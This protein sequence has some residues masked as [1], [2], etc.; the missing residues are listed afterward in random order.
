[1]NRDLMLQVADFIDNLPPSKFSM[2]VWVG[3]RYGEYSVDRHYTSCIVDGETYD[4]LDDAVEDCGTV[5]CIAGWT[6]LLAND[7]ADRDYNYLWRVME[8]FEL[9]YEESRE[10]CHNL[11]DGMTAWER[12]WPELIKNDRLLTKDFAYDGQDNITHKMAAQML[13]RL[14]NNEW[15]LTATINR[16][17]ELDEWRKQEITYVRD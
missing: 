3:R 11:C 16:Q 1:M 12:Y 14:A 5:G 17:K 6:V 10:L 13:R 9:T 4:S 8:L 7:S 2:N 15:Q